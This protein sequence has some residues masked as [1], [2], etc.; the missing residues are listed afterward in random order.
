MRLTKTV[1]DMTICAF[2][3]FLFGI[4]WSK[5]IIVMIDEPF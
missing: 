2:V 3:L 1:M 4:I 5:R